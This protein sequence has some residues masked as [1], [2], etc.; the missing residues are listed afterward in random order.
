MI[1]D[2]LGRFAMKQLWPNL[3]ILPRHFPLEK[4]EENHEI[5]IIIRTAVNSGSMVSVIMGAPFLLFL[6]MRWHK[7]TAPAQCTC[8]EDPNVCRGEYLADRV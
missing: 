1:S 4:T 3:G 7:Y 2:E 8:T 5:T 6:R